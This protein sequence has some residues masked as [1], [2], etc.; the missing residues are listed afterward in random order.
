MIYDGG[1]LEMRFRGRDGRVWAARS[2]NVL[3]TRWYHVAA[4][5]NVADGLSLYVNGDL[6]DRDQLPR[7]RPGTGT[8]G[9]DEFLIGRP[10]DEMRVTERHLMAVDD[11]HFWSE[12]KDASDIKQLGLPVIG[13]RI[14]F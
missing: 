9:S 8:V 2:D 6:V 14:N 7:S 1:N 13:Q 5:W 12:Y 11:F 10:N 4:A 3:P